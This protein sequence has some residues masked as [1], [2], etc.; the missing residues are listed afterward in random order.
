M[1][2]LHVNYLGELRTKGL[3]IASNDTFIT[4]APLDNNGRG[5]AF[6][7]TDLMSAS[8]VSCMMT[9]MGITAEKHSI[10]FNSAEAEIEKI[11]ASDPRRVS[12]IRIKMHVSGGPFDQREKAILENAAKTCPV[13]RSLHPELV[14]NIRFSYDS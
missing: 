6:S 12:E 1:S 10:E 5:E 2:K 7:P 11:M 9:I 13:A 14:Q 3:H 8:L 4:D